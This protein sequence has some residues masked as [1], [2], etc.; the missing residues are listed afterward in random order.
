MIMYPLLRSPIFDSSFSVIH[1]ILDFMGNVAT[2]RLDIQA[3]LQFSIWSFLYF[4][5]FKYLTLV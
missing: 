1:R 3:K 5:I 2:F 4:Q